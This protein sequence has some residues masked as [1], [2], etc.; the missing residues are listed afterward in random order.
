MAGDASKW[1]VFLC[2][3]RVGQA[4]ATRDAR[5]EG[6]GQTRSLSRP[7]QRHNVLLPL[8]G[9]YLGWYGLG[10]RASR[11]QR[12]AMQAAYGRRRYVCRCPDDSEAARTGR[13]DV[14]AGRLPSNKA[15]SVGGDARA[16][17]LHLK[18]MMLHV[19][20]VHVRVV[21][22]GACEPKWKD[23]KRAGPA[24]DRVRH[25]RVC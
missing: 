21:V 4:D 11:V 6:G 22:V 25:G 14:R 17:R 16:S 10:G 23:T 13:L 3:A 15:T 9:R 2:Q 5:R 18:G 24:D 8:V 12:L 20:V 19:R 1:R 7:G